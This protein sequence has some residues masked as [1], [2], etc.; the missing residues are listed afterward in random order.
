MFPQ[1]ISTRRPWAIWNELLELP[2]NR[3]RIAEGL[4]EA[5]TVLIE[6]ADQVLPTSR[7]LCRLHFIVFG[8]VLP[9]QAGRFRGPDLPVNVTFGGSHRGADYTTV[10]HDMQQIEAHALELVKQL[11]EQQRAGRLQPFD[12]V[13]VAAWHHA[14]VIRTHPFPDGNGRMSRLCLN[15]YAYRYGLEEFSLDGPKDDR[16]IQ[17]LSWFV[18]RNDPEPLAKYLATKMIPP[19]PDEPAR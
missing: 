5:K 7:L 11:D 15:F 4:L 19:S 16:Y 1:P 14:R 6:R 12:V 8:A 9:E 2:E 10:A 18:S 13:R 3:D 17:T